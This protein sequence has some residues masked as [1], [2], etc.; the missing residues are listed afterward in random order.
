MA[1]FKSV[2]SELINTDNGFFVRIVESNDDLWSVAA[3][4][5][6]D[7]CNIMAH[8]IR[9]SEAE[10]FVDHYAEGLKASGEIVIEPLGQG[11]SCDR[12]VNFRLCLPCD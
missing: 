1:W 3:G 2:D 12:I 4:L 11:R 8:D 6:V 10:D 7:A 5:S 9:L